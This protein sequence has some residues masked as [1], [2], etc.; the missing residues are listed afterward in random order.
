MTDTP[1]FTKTE[2]KNQSLTSL[3]STGITQYV[4]LPTPLSSTSSFSVLNA[5]ILSG[6]LGGSASTSG[7]PFT[8]DDKGVTVKAMDTTTL[9]VTYYMH[10]R[11]QGSSGSSGN[12]TTVISGTNLVSRIIYVIA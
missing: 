6:N 8:E 10:F 1:A 2:Q 12:C 3:V 4:T 7:G 9:A 11:F 5:Y